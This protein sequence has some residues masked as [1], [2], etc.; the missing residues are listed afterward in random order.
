[1]TLATIDF[2]TRV[3]S[4]V[5]R[6]VER[7]RNFDAIV[8]NF[9]NRDWRRQWTTAFSAIALQ[10]RPPCRFCHKP[11]PPDRIR[12]HEECAMSGLDSR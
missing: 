9:G 4:E 7:G 12:Y 3:M 11:L 6:S 1:M 10:G 5:K 8:Y 2:L